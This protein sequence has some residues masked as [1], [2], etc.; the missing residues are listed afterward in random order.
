MNACRHPQQASLL[1]FADGETGF[2]E[3][4]RVRGHLR[5]CSSCRAEIA[6]MQSA[7]MDFA[8]VRSHWAPP[9]PDWPSLEPRMAEQRSARL[10]APQPQ[11][12]ILLRPLVVIA[13][14]AVV[15]A[16]AI[17]LI[18]FN[19]GAHTAKIPTPAPVSH[20]PVP[21]R[22]TPRPEPVKPPRPTT[23]PTPDRNVEVR[24][25]A[26]IH[27]IGADLGE[28]VA[29]TY[30][31]GW[32]IVATA[33][34]PERLDEIRDALAGLPVRVRASHPPS[35]EPLPGPSAGLI[36]RQGSAALE[37]ALGGRAAFETLAN[38]ILEQ[39]DALLARAFALRNLDR[40]FPSA[41]AIPG[42]AERQ[43][44]HGMR[45]DHLRAYASHARRLRRLTG[46]IRD[47]IQAPATGSV[48]PPSLSPADAAFELDRVLS[49]LLASSGMPTS[50][51]AAELSAALA[52][53]TAGAQ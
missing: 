26:A 44:L 10:L 45:Q 8:M 48:R 39:N 49:S 22:Q 37:A 21:A 42:A 7:M 13:L 17:L 2:V 31:G 3:G 35:A 29:L 18:P 47:A 51:Q 20:P 43:M 11:A 30:D 38:D 52:A 6:A 34:D 50:Q 46:P 53:V 12:R 4:W 16:A 32:T 19:Q 23:P 40:R 15:L 28:P 25:L 9:E 27:R 24:A 33:L 14:G 36:H 1:R 41:A 5:N